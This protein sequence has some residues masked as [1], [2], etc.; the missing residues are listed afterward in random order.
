MCLLRASF[1]NFCDRDI[2]LF[3]RWQY[4]AAHLA[5]PVRRLQLPSLRHPAV[6]TIAPVKNS[7]PPSSRFLLALFQRLW[8]I[9]EEVDRSVFVEMEG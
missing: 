2:S 1:V 9:L 7:I 3:E 8:T 5:F 4:S 6:L